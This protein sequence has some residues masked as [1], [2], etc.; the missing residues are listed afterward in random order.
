MIFY[1]FHNK[2]KEF[3]FGLR[4]TITNTSV[5][6]LSNIIKFFHTALP[7]IGVAV[8]PA[9]ECG[10]C[11]RSHFK[12]PDPHL[13]ASKY[14]E[15]KEIFPDMDISYSGI[16]GIGNLRQIFCGLSVPQ[17]AVLPSGFVTACFGYSLEEFSRQ[18]FIYGHYDFNGNEFVF[19]PEKIQWLR[20]FVLNQYQVCI[21]CFAK[22]HC[23]G[24]CPALRL[25]MDNQFIA[26]IQRMRCVIN[27]EVAKWHLVKEVREHENRQRD[28]S[29]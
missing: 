13:F 17:F 11:K 21:D 6:E 8:E 29:V 5:E 3:R 22:Y 27:R 26:M 18:E 2:R 19:I 23:A 10:R 1:E 12:S 20:N 25:A 24:D 16:G 7:G 28:D 15:I 14:I 9:E 4:P